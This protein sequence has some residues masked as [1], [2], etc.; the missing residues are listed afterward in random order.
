MN[1]DTTGSLTCRRIAGDYI[2]VTSTG[3]SYVYLLTE[4]ERFLESTR[5]VEV[6]INECHPNRGAI[7]RVA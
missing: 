1:C 7:S 2:I 4:P 5:I 6:A 3:I